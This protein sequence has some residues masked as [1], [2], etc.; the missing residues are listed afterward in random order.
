[1]GI[2]LGAYFLLAFLLI[3]HVNFALLNTGHFKLLVPAI[4]TVVNS[5]GFATI[6]PTLRTYF[7]SNVKQLRLI[8]GIGSLIPLICYI[9]WN[10]TVQGSIG[11]TGSDGLIHMALSGHS[12]S[13]LTDALSTQMHSEFISALAHLFISICLTTSFLGVG[14]CLTDFLADGLHIKKVGATQWLIMALT[15]LPPL[16]IILFPP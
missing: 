11:T 5:F 9:L 16:L 7:N 6:I 12:A 4:M 10:F 8:V 14:L 13:D 15:F 1:M 3:P 2:K